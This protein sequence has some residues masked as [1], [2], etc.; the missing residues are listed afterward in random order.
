MVCG[1][2]II[3]T[4]LYFIRQNLKKMQKTEE[5]TNEYP[6]SIKNITIND[7][8]TSWTKARAYHFGSKHWYT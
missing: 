2:Q 3:I 4:I 8:H 7:Y 1:T 6:H 5:F